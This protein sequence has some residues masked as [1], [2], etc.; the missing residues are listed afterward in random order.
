MLT[1]DD[2]R[3]RLPLV[4]SFDAAHLEV[5]DQHPVCQR[6]FRRLQPRLLHAH[7]LPLYVGFFPGTPAKVEECG[8]EAMDRWN[9]QMAKHTAI[10]GGMFARWEPGVTPLDLMI[11]A[12]LFSWGEVSF[13]FGSWQGSFG[14]PVGREELGEC[15]LYWNEGL[16]VQAGKLFVP[17]DLARRDT[18]STL[19]HELGHGGKLGHSPHVPSDIMFRYH[20]DVQKPSKK[21]CRWAEEIWT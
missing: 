20:T 18:T 6:K 12:K 9:D 10:T 2:I 21:E 17:P 16:I 7:P 5:L 3:L 4:N 11:G 13:D 8:L 19:G 14:N 1:A 15:T